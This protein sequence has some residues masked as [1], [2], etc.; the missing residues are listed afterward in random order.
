MLGDGDYTIPKRI[1]TNF[2]IYKLIST[3]KYDTSISLSFLVTTKGEV[4]VMGD[5]SNNQAGLGTSYGPSIR[6]PTLIKS[7]QGITDIST[8]GFHTLSVNSTGVFGFGMFFFSF[9]L[10]IIF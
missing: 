1:P 7:L 5:N 8:S 10:L 6:Q 2:D 9:I 4:Y 3:T